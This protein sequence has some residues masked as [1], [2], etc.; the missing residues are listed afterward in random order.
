MKIE[1]K[2]FNYRLVLVVPLMDKALGNIRKLIYP[3]P[4]NIYLDFHCKTSLSLKFM[5]RGA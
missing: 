3:S 1:L 5:R 4:N 2:W